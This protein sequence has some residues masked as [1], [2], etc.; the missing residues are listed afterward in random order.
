MKIGSL[1]FS[2]ISGGAAIAA[3]RIHC[4]LRK[5]GVDVSM[6][7]NLSLSEDATVQGPQNIFEKAVPKIARVL[8]R[9]SA[10]TFLHTGNPVIHSPAHIPSRIPRYVNHSDFALIHLHWINGEMIS[11][12][13]IAKLSKPLIWTLHDMWAFCG[14]EHYTQDKRWSRGYLPK[15]RPDYEFGFDLNRWVW[16]RKC[17]HWK[18]PIQIVTPSHWLADCVRQSVLMKDWPVQVIH[19]C[20][21]TDAWYPKDKLLAREYFNLPKDRPLILFGAMKAKSDPRKGFQLLRLAMEI[22]YERSNIPSLEMVV[23]GVPKSR[24]LPDFVFPIHY[25]GYIYDESI[26]NLLYS[27]VDVMAIP[28]VMDNLPN[29]G[30]EALSSGTPVIAFNTCGLSDIVKHLQTG[31]L[32]KAFEVEDLAKGI[33]WILTDHKRYGELSQESRKYAVETFSYPVVAEKYY[34]LYKKILCIH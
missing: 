11:I 28:S 4:A 26:L 34:R 32:A 3:Y 20:L 33:E 25:K 23:F 17:K 12:S 5:Y 15:N 8:G 2:D 18:Q 29:T 1:S 9:I 13:D 27:A 31:Y 22:L 16:E 24:K 10:R 6:R 19:N 21:D 30:I 14:A 7:V